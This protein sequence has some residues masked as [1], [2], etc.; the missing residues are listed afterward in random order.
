MELLAELPR[1]A[2]TDHLFSF[3]GRTPPQNFSSG[4][5]QLD[6]LMGDV[7]AWVTHDLRRT[8]RTRLAA[9]RIPDNIGEMI[10]G[11]GKRGLQRVYDQHSYVD[12]MRAAFAAWAQRLQAIVAPPPANVVSWRAA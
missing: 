7:P 4:K 2:G 6:E 5:A 9:L 3:N 11:H 10:I 1:W 8:V 12:E